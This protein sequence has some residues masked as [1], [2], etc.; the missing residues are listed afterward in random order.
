MNTRLNELKAQ[1]KALGSVNVSAIEEYAEVKER[2]DFVSVQ[3]N[4]LSAS[5]ADLLN[6]IESIDDEMTRMFTEAFEK[7]N[8]NFGEVFRELF[9]GGEAHLTL[10]DPENVLTSGI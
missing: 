1:I 6:I 2:Y 9:G 5:K 7:I 8:T 4:D 10:T 3:M